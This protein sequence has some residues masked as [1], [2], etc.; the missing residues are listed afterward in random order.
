MDNNCI[1][2]YTY[3]NKLNS[4]LYIYD[5]DEKKSLEIKLG[6]KMIKG[7]HSIFVGK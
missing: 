5:I 1:V 7:F 2:C 3:D 6:I 4:Y